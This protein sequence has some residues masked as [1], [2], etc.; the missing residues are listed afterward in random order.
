MC[1]IILPC[2]NVIWLSRYYPH[3]DK[4]AKHMKRSRR[5]HLAHQIAE[6]RTW[7]LEKVGTCAS[8]EICAMM[9]FVPFQAH[10]S[11]SLLHWSS[12]SSTQH[13]CLRV[14]HTHMYRSSCI[15]MNFPVGKL[16]IQWVWLCRSTFD[17]WRRVISTFPSWTMCPCHNFIPFS[18]KFASIII[19]I[20]WRCWETMSWIIPLIAWMSIVW[21]PIHLMCTLFFRFFL[22]GNLRMYTRKPE[23]KLCL[24][25]YTYMFKVHDFIT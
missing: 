10:C 17:A 7:V 2:Y 3:W 16:I 15:Q 25:T 23:G 6:I 18:E 19:I 14:V 21:Y 4:C 11:S 24:C 9:W 12:S 22:P 1:A 8:W 5:A 20:A 13:E